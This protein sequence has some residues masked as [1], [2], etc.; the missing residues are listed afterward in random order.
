MPPLAFMIRLGLRG[1][2]I[3]ISNQFQV[4]VMLLGL[5][6]NLET[7]TLAGCTVRLQRAWL[8]C[9]EVARSLRSAVSYFMNPGFP[10]RLNNNP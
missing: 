10:S 6:P 9:K 5:G 4:T 2:R 7:T 3:F 8:L 1:L